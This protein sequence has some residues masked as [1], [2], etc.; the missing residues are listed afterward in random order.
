MSEQAA[1][2][3][4]V[5]M[6]LRQINYSADPVAP[7][8]TGID[9]TF[10]NSPIGYTVTSGTMNFDGSATV[11]ISAALV[12]PGSNLLADATCLLLSI[13]CRVATVQVP[14][15]LLGDHP[16]VDPSNSTYT[17]FYRNKW[18]EV[19]YYAVAPGIAPSG[20]RSC[21]TSSTCLQVTYHPN[22][23]KQRGVIIIAG[24]KLGTQV[25]PATAPSHLFEGANA[26][27][28]SPFE[29]RSATLPTN[30]AFNDHFAV[31]D[32]NP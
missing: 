10:V 11:R 20:A 13:G 9:T 29:L 24:P 25:R 16:V 6:T 18:H 26:D 7:P 21:T 19:S 2:A 1:T 17:W 27:G 15:A 4:N 3:N 8:I 5:G 14:M 31:I 23:G 30:R 22:D 28:A 12:N 32:S